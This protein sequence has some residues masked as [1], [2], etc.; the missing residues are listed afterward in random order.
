MDALVKTA[1]ALAEYL[2]RD[3]K[4]RYT[5]LPYATHLEEVAGYVRDA[6]L[7]P[8]AEAAAWLHDSIEDVGA[9]HVMLVKELG[10]GDDAVA[11]AD[12]VVWLTD[13]EHFDA[14]LK[15]KSRTIRKAAKVV[16]IK[17]APYLAKSVKLAN[18]L[19]NTSDIAENDPAFAKSKYV[20]EMDALLTALVGG[21]ADLWK[22]AANSISAAKAKLGLVV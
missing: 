1:R 19:S 15:A 3:H 11:V 18:V 16:K 10:G 2:H 17:D 9:N 7:G 5:G 20:S 13:P 6:G 8:I 4:R 12:L 14:G 21:H 22:K